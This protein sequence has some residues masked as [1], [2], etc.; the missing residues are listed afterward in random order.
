MKGEP[1]FQQQ[2][3]PSWGAPP[4]WQQP[5]Y[6]P[7]DGCGI[8]NVRTVANEAEAR[9]CVCPLGS[10][11]LLMDASEPRF[12]VKET[13][14]N[15]VST[16]KAYEFHEVT[17]TPKRSD[18]ITRAEF[19]EW[20]ANHEPAVQPEAD[21]AATGYAEAAPDDGGVH[22]RAGKGRGSANRR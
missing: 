7:P 2:P 16:L 15:N 4:M 13:D 5:Q 8:Q 3:Y 22:A 14:F 17:D 11:V 10:R 9:Q 6:R 20:K 18:Y 19:E 21:Q 1:M 12:Y